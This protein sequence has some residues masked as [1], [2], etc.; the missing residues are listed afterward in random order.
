MKTIELIAMV[1][2]K[3][4]CLAAYVK[5]GNLQYAIMLLLTVLI[6]DVS[7]IVEILKANP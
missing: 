5:T 2:M 6:S 4:A 3:I 7:K 1:A